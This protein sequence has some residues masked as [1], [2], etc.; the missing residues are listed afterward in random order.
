MMRTWKLD[1]SSQA[2]KLKGKPFQARIKFH[3]SLPNASEGTLYISHWEVGAPDSTRYTI[4]PLQQLPADSF[5][6]FEIPANELDEKGNLII[7]FVNENEMAL[8]FGLD[9]GLEVLYPE[10]SFGV[11]FIRG[12]G[13]ILCWLTLLAAIGLAASSW[14]SFPVA[15]F[16]SIAVLIIGLSSGTFSNA[17][18]QG[19]I[20]GLDHETSKP[21]NPALDSIVLPVFKGILAILQLV[22]NFSPIDSLSTGRSIT[23]GQLGL[24][25]AQ[26]VGLMGGIF[27]AAG[28]GL[29]TRRELASVQ[30]SA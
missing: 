16:F 23:W 15:A 25:A 7:S 21:S 2:S 3:S 30:S 8:L 1:L 19:T 17:I 10:G 11:N 9:D 18:E 22:E 4:L 20:L 5:Q 26:I 14:L 29:F 24:A 12:L 6:E 28:M 13:I 27:A